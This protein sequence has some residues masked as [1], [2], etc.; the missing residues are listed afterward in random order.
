MHLV[1]DIVYESWWTKNIMSLES[2]SYAP[3]HEFWTGIN[4]SDADQY[5]ANM[6]YSGFISKH[7][8]EH[9]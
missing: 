6:D 4:F 3:K 1:E 5:W 2:Y 9:L 8:F 7:G